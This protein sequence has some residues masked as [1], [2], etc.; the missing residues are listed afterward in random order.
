MRSWAEFG[1]EL[2]CIVPYAYWHHQRGLLLATVGVEGSAA[3]FF[4]S[5][6][7]IEV[8]N[9]VRHQD[10]HAV[11]GIEAGVDG[12]NKRNHVVPFQLHRWAM[13]P[14][15]MH[16]R[17][18]P[19]A[20]TL[21][22][23]WPRLVIVHNKR[24]DWPTKPGH[25]SEFSEHQL[26]QLLG[27]LGRHRMQ[28]LYICPSGDGPGRGF[29]HDHR[30]GK[31]EVRRLSCLQANYRKVLASH[32]AVL[33]QDVLD[34]F[35]IGWNE[36]QYAAHAS[37]RCFVSCQGGTAIISSLFG[38]INL[39]YDVWPDSGERSTGE[40]HRLHAAFSNVS[41]RVATSFENLVNQTEELDII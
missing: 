11:Y 33:L 40:Y 17:Q 6:S 31:A 25:R 7:H 16:Y 27:T 22:R 38:G 41:I 37:A 29:T 1:Y 34:E 13:P 35:G 10:N 9:M 15:A 18:H 36:G 8:R 21:R 19:L 26:A 30:D 14:F 4:F 3:S 2:V 12:L 5:P 32:S 39:I 23:R 20:T 24:S 28:V